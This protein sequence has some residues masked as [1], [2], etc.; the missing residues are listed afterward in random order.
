M[1]F[2]KKA[3]TQLSC[4]ILTVATKSYHENNNCI[5]FQ[6]QLHAS[7]FF[8]IQSQWKIPSLAGQKNIFHFLLADTY[9]VGNSCLR[10]RAIGVQI[11]FLHIITKSWFCYPVFK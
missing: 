9:A 5:I 3:N 8:K 2:F 6:Q 1:L 4:L 10:S 7:V 11:L